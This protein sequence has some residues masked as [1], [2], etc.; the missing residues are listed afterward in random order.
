[1]AVNTQVTTDPG[2]SCPH[3][4][5]LGVAQDIEPQS[6]Y[7]KFDGASA[8]GS[9]YA[10]LTLKTTDG[11]VISRTR[12]DQV[13][14]IGDSGVVTFAPFLHSVVEVPAV[15]GYVPYV[16]S[17]FDSGSGFTMYVVGRV[18]TDPGQDPSDVSTASANT[19]VAPFY[20]SGADLIVWLNAGSVWIAAPDGTGETKIWDAATHAFTANVPSISPDGTTVLFAATQGGSA[21]TI[22]RCDTDGANLTTL[23]TDPSNRNMAC[24]SYSHD[25]TKIAFEVLLSSTQRGLW[26]MDADGSNAT[27]VGIIP[28]QFSGIY[29]DDPPYAWANL[30][31]VLAYPGNTLASLSNVKVNA[32]GTGSTTLL[33]AGNGHSITWHSWSSDDGLIY[34]VPSTETQL[35]GILTDGSGTTSLVYTWASNH[36]NP[37]FMFSGRVYQR[38]TNFPSTPTID[39]VLEAGSGEREEAGGSP[40]TYSLV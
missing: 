9:F 16:R 1:V 20:G 35:R 12:P 22:Q 38:K 8:S 18:T 10:C 29:T 39:S 5:T 40:N 3:T 25:G 4:L 30:S 15:A 34:Y 32:D 26:T 14:A 21:D 37:P 23:Y 11:T 31:N 36:P 19:V 6:V 33:S 13:F 27:Q 2:G 28:T 24:P 7:V 17:Y